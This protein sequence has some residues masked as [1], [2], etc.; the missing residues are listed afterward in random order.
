MPIPCS[1]LSASP[2]FPLSPFFLSPLPCSRQALT[3]G[4]GREHDSFLKGQT[5]FVGIGK[6]KM[7]MERFGDF[8]PNLISF[9]LR[10]LRYKLRYHTGSQISRKI[11]N[12]SIYLAFGIVDFYSFRTVQGFQEFTFHF[13]KLSPI[14]VCSI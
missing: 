11:A 13:Q 5:L 3:G 4:G 9:R 10:Y 1:T 2:P 6:N 7:Q 12:N 8:A 14:L